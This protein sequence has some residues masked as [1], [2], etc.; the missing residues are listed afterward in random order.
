MNP[1]KLVYKPHSSNQVKVF[2]EYK[3]GHLEPMGLLYHNEI[4][5]NQIPTEQILIIR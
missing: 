5:D 3:G 1:D 4:P 2:A